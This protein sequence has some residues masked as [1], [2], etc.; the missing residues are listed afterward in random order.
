MNVFLP[1]VPL[2]AVKLLQL[3]AA[4]TFFCLSPSKTIGVILQVLIVH[5]LNYPKL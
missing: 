3:A 2:V 1:E 4:A 5:N